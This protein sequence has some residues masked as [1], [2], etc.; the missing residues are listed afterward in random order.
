MRSSTTAAER[1]RG[2]EEQPWDCWP[3]WVNGRTDGN[4]F[5]LLEKRVQCIVCYIVCS[6]IWLDVGLYTRAMGEN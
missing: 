4:G 1:R 3:F 6:V 2:G 5:L